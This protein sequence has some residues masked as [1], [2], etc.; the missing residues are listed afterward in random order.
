MPPAEL[1]S[2]ACISV[3]PD[4]EADG[5]VRI[6]ELPGGRHAVLHH[7]GLYAEPEAAYLWLYRKWLPNSGEEAADRPCFEEYLYNPKN[8]AA[9]EWR[10][11]I[12][13]PLR[14]R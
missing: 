14:H 2:E 5:D 9:E 13:L 11:D 10:T 8:S 1:R 7:Q 6:L 4:I 12:C 3:G